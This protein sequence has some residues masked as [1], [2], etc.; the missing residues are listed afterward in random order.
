MKVLKICADQ[1]PY[2]DEIGKDL[3]DLQ[4][5]V[6]GYI[7]CIYME[8]GKT[9]LICNEEGKINGL[10]LNRIVYNVEGKPYDVIAGDFIIVGDDDDDFRS[11]TDDEIAYYSDV[12]SLSNSN[13]TDKFK[14]VILGW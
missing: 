12:M 11:L 4:A 2:V 14:K 3:D 8:D 6:G 7:E 5:A 1:E 13:Y 10:P 9:I